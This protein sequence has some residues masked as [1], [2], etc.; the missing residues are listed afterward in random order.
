MA[1][2]LNSAEFNYAGSGEVYLAPVGTAMPAAETTALNA[3]FLGLGYTTEDGVSI[4]PTIEMNE[5]RS[6]QSAYATDR[7]VN[8]RDLTISATLQQLNNVTFRTNF[9]GGSF[10]LGTGTY[11]YT[12]P[13]EADID[14]K[15]MII[16]WVDGT[17]ITRLLVPKVLVSE[18]GALQLQRA[19]P[20]EIAITWGLISTGVGNPF[21]VVSNR[22]EFAT[23]V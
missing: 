16:H 8:S 15:A 7:R 3:A 21:T 9:G 23:P 12:P 4:Q 17:E 13:A 11:T 19:T 10:A 5:V 6:W 2:N 18:S 14:Y 22:A 20:T 1:A